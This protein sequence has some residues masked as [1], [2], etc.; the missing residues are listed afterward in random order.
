MDSGHF[1]GSRVTNSYISSNPFYGHWLPAHCVF[2]CHNRV[3]I[4][5]IVLSY[6]DDRFL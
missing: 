5:D 4:A 2:H 3:L 6:N 1:S